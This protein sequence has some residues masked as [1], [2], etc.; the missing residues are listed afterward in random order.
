M[1][2]FGKFAVLLLALSLFASPVMACLSPDIFLTDEERDCC[3]QMAGDCSQMPAS[4]SCCQMTIRGS[5]PYLVNSRLATPVPVPVAVDLQACEM[6]GLPER[7]SLFAD[8]ANWHAPPRSS[9]VNFSL[10]RI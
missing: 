1:K 4:H 10:L 8:A 7:F 5:D 9:P 6:V 2:T 3:Q